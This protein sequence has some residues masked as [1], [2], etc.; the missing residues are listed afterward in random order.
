VFLANGR[1]LEPLP[2]GADAPAIE[3][4][5]GVRRSAETLAEKV[6]KPGEAPIEGAVPLW[7][8]FALQD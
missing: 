5:A 2:D 6:R 4:A 3:A 7:I 8:E 1:L